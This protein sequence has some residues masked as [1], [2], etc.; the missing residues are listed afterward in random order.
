MSGADIRSNSSSISNAYRSRDFNRLAQ[1]DL[2]T[3]VNSNGENIVHII[4]RVQ[5]VEA[6]DKLKKMNAASLKNALNKQENVHGDTPVHTAMKNNTA[7][8]NTSQG[9]FIDKLIESGANPNIE[10]HNG[11]IVIAN[12]NSTGDESVLKNI[13]TLFS[14]KEPASVLSSSESDNTI[15]FIK[16]LTDH[17]FNKPQLKGGYDISTDSFDM[18]DID[19]DD[20]RT[21]QDRPKFQGE[22]IDAYNKILEDIMKIMKVD[23]ETAKIY[24][25]ALKWRVTQKN[26]E[27]RKRENDALKVK[28]IEKLFKDP[29]EAKRVMTEEIDLEEVK[30][31]ISQQRAENDERRKNDSGKKGSKSSDKKSNDSKSN[32]SKTKNDT[33]KKATAKK[34]TSAETRSATSRSNRVMARDGYLM[35]D[36]IDLDS[37]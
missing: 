5:D 1:F 31:V 35:T 12:R 18:S 7:S 25:S 22:I 36:D 20:F 34:T 29:K 3:P 11:I 6:I 30:K 17:Y 9:S 21:Y 28:E 16:R 24:R 15:E 2:S 19:M 10:N 4:C 14:S 27:L 23:E 8:K 33:V 13:Q 26:P 32:N 37:D